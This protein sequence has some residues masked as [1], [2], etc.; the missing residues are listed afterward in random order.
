MTKLKPNPS[1]F[2]GVIYDP[3]IKGRVPTWQ[4]VFDN[5]SD[6]T[7]YAGK[8]AQKTGHGEVYLGPVLIN[9]ECEPMKVVL[10]DTCIDD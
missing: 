9:A 8:L 6:A 1:G 2:W 10:V 5:S 7:D 3:C 4:A